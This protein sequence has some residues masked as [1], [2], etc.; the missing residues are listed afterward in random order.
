LLVFFVV[1][2]AADIA[3]QI[4]MHRLTGHSPADAAGWTTAGAALLFAAALLGLYAVLVRS[5]EHRDVRELAPRP[6][7][8]VAGIVLGVA[9]FSSVFGLLHLIG[10]ARWQGVAG[11]FDV[12]MLAVSIL[13]GVGEELAFRGALFRIVEEG[14]GTTSALVTSAAVFGLLHALNPGATVISTTAVALE[15]GILLAAAYALTRNLWFPIGL[16]F[17]WNFTEGGIFG[18]SVSGGPAVKGIFSVTLTGR[19][20]LTGGKFGPEASVI[21]IAL[22]LAVGVVLL[23]LTVRRG[24]WMSLQ[25][26]RQRTARD[27]H[28]AMLWAAVSLLALSLTRSAHAGCVT[29]LAKNGSSG[30]VNE[31]V[32]FNL[33]N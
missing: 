21:A 6:I 12:T 8:A 30:P 27:S 24:G 11:H 22:C 1:L 7:Q 29:A 33:S 32:D 25:S 26:V 13:A 9:L 15:A 23:V 19:T 14:F 31:L 3:V 18:V 2:L 20:L 4:G 17:G 28:P 16:H 5:M 10:V